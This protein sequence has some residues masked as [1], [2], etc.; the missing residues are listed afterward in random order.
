[1]IRQMTSDDISRIGEVWLEASIKAHDFVSADFWRSNHKTMTEELLP[2][3]EGYVHLTGERV[4]GFS[5]V[6]GDFVHCLFVE[7]QSQRRGIGAELLDHL[8]ASHQAL[9]LHV[10]QQNPD[11]TRFYTTHGFVITG[12]ATCPHTKCAEFA[13]EW[14]KEPEPED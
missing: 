14:K 10:Y 1:M 12:E 6:D 2:Q 4:D 3:A 8:K 5:T 11:V 13:M 7:P 9:R